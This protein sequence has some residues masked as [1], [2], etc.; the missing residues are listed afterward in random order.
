MKIIDFN[1]I[2]NADR[3]RVSAVVLWEDCDQPR[4][5]IFIE[6]PPYFGPDVNPDP[7][8]FLVGCAVPALHFKERR[9]A[10]DR[11]ICPSF[12]EGLRTAMAVLSHWSNDAWRPP[13]VEAKVRRSPVYKRANRRAALFLSGGIDSL[14]ALRVNRR[15]HPLDHPGAV[16]D[17]FVLHG[18]D[19]GGVVRRG[20][21]YPVFHRTLEALE[22]VARE[23]RLVLIPVFTNIRH[24]CD[25][26]DLWL[27]RFFGAVLAAVSHAF[28]KRVSLSYIASSYDIAHLHPCGSHPLLDPFYSRL[29]MRILHRDLELTRME[30]IRTVV[31]WDTAFQNMRVCLANVP[32]R[33]N[34]GKCEKCVRTMLALAAL[35]V[36]HK[37]R[38]FA[39]DDV[40]PEDL[41]GFSIRIRDRESFYR[42]LIPWLAAA[43]R[44]DLVDAIAY[45]LEH[46]TTA[47]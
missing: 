1:K 46:D 37:T 9:I 10:L 18:F 42:E 19:I 47:A 4:R 13:A 11:R 14:A 23:A 25:D 15:T 20:M 32:D 12:L 26:R 41:S 17:G 16:K 44:A 31:Q 39:E 6:T 5:E 7:H 45:K 34:C 43:G 24:L 36:L 35:N 29:D 28:S 38:A 27:N 3:T 30:K 40:F 33:L 8:A 21:K 22:P 2:E